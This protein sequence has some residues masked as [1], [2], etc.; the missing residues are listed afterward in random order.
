[1]NEY[2]LLKVI[3]HPNLNILYMDVEMFGE[4][5]S[6]DVPTLVVGYSFNTIRIAVQKLKTKKEMLKTFK[7]MEDSEK[8]KKIYG[9]KD[10]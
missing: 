4:A 6:S 7:S 2:F 9:T 3:Q 5:Y 10:K 1:M 8:N